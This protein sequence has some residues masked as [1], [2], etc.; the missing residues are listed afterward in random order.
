MISRAC[1]LLEEQLKNFGN[2]SCGR[3]RAS[4][5]LYQSTMFS[6]SWTVSDSF[7]NIRDGLLYGFGV[8]QYAWSR[9]L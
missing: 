6:Q 2:E 3:T 4:E 8:L 5:V 7:G 9:T 1:M